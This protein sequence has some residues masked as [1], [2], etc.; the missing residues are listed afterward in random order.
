MKF[1]DSLKDKRHFERVLAELDRSIGKTKKRLDSSSGSRSYLHSKKVKRIS[2]VMEWRISEKISAMYSCGYPVEDLKPLFSEWLVYAGNSLE[3]YTCPSIPLYGLN[4]G[5]LLGFSNED[6]QNMQ[7]LI[8]G[9]ERTDP[10]LAFIARL[11]GFSYDLGIP[12]V[13]SSGDSWWRWFPLVR[14]MQTKRERERYLELYLKKKWYSAQQ[15]YYWWDFHKR[16]PEDYFGYWAF[17]IA[18]AARVYGLDDTAFADHR[19][20]PSDLAHYLG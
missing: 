7:K 10:L 4:L 6:R 18:A 19:H 20:Y 3:D 1:R 15:R 13:G 9:V 2:F 14:S 16:L 8:D 12:D 5:T 11:H 17:D